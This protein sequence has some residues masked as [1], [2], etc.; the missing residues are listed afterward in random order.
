M[1]ANL[2]D[3][4]HDA[5]TGA[6]VAERP[7]MYPPGAFV[8]STMRRV[9]AGDGGAVR[10]LALSGPLSTL[11]PP[12]TVHGSETK[13][14]WSALESGLIWALPPASCLNIA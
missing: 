10:F 13:A 6:A 7:R 8:P 4:G 2:E 9:C 12:A 5:G 1:H 3:A 11:L 14:D